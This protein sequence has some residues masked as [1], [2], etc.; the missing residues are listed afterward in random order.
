MYKILVEQ[1]NDG[2]YMIDLHTG[3]ILFSNLAFARMSGHTTEELE[4]RCIED[5]YLPEDRHRMKS[6]LRR[7]L[8]GEKVV[9]EFFAEITVKKY[10]TTIIAKLGVSDRTQVAIVALRM[11]L[12][13]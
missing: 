13:Q 9:E 7:V 2:L 11:G 6:V 4:G 8:R 5:I 1:A 12:V 10:V 3:K